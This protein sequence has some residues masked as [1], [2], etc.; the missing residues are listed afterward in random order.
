MEL[1]IG[2]IGHPIG[3]LT[4]VRVQCCPL[5]EGHLDAVYHL[6]AYLR[7]HNIAAIN[8]IKPCRILGEN[9]FTTIHEKINK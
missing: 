4:L 6:F 3:S 2:Q 5:R 7:K 9:L 1:R 8:L